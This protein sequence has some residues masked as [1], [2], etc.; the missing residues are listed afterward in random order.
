MA[1]LVATTRR[2]D[3]DVDLLAAAGADGV[4][5]ERGRGGLAGRGVALRVRCDEVGVPGCGPV[6]LG[7]LPFHPDALPAAELV[8]PSVVWGRAEDG[9]RWVTTIGDADVPSPVPP[10]AARRSAPGAL[11]VAPSR[12]AA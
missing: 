8:V 12:P 5:F 7:A 9:T 3:G 4:L 2:L 1:E 6:A 11:R 10:S